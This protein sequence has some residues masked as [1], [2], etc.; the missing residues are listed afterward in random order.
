MA[1]KLSEEEIDDLI[2]FSRSGEKEEFFPQL[3]SLAEREK[4]S[5]AEILSS[6][7]DAGQSTCLHMA[8]GNG[9]LGEFGFLIPAPIFFF[10]VPN[11]LV[12]YHLKRSA[13]S[14]GPLSSADV[15][16]SRG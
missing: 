11:S 6:A 15:S 16:A 10:F 7:K 4:L 8:T 2:Y 5:Q 12:A 1:P 9:H 14:L 13:V 3:S